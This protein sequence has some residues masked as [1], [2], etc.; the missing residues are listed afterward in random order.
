MV[1][2]V[3]C[4]SPKV[5]YDYDRSAHFNDYRT[6]EWGPGTPQATGDPRIDNP[7]LDAHIRSAVVAELRS[8][9]FTTPAQGK[10]DFYQS[11]ARERSGRASPL[12]ALHRTKH[13]EN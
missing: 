4:A 2:A 6:Y 3:A 12:E 1:L 8:K 13:I 9:G 11:R 7:L 10:P 5:G